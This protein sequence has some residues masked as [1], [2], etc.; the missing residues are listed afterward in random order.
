[1]SVKPHDTHTHTHIYM[2]EVTPAVQGSVQGVVCCVVCVCKMVPNIIHAGSRDLISS[3]CFIST[4]PGPIRL[5]GI[6]GPKVC[7]YNLYRGG[8]PPSRYTWSDDSNAVGNGRG[9]SLYNPIPKT[10]PFFAR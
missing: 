3:V 8:L 6:I 10:R 7:S 1:M 4:P 5:I 2:Q 9:P